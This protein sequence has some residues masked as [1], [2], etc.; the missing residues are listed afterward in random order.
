[1]TYNAPVLL[2]IK[3]NN[4]MYRML[5]YSMSTY[6]GVTNFKKQ[7]RFLAHPV[8]PLCTQHSGLRRLRAFMRCLLLENGL[9]NHK[10]DS[11]VL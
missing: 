2:W 4:L 10:T 8:V 9:A 11:I 5:F 3:L 1:V 7:S 6:T